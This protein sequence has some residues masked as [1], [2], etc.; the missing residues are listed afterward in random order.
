MC[1]RDSPYI[2]YGGSISPFVN[3]NS[4][5]EIFGI[6]PHHNN[7]DIMTACYEG[8]ALSIK[9]CYEALNIKMKSLSL[10]G[11][12]SKSLIFPQILS[13]VLGIK[14]IIPSGKEFGAR[15]AAYMAAVSIK[16]Y[17]NINQAVKVN[18]KIKKI[19]Y[20]NTKNKYYYSKKYHTYIKLRKTLSNIW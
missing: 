6:L 12:A 1:I 2:N 9:D 11:G 3:L 17:K 7:F 8:L 19:F 10:S 5:A 18:K 15:G 16:K 13:D 20:P 14:I 4:K